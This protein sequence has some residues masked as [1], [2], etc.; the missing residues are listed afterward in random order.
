[1]SKQSKPATGEMSRRRFLG[2]AAVGGGALI[3]VTFGA[4]PAAAGGKMSQSSVKYQPHPK[5]KQQCSNCAL[6]VAPASCKVVEGP[7]SPEGWCQI[8]APK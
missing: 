3:A 6:F 1:M 7:I 2:T 5:G 8:Y 4:R